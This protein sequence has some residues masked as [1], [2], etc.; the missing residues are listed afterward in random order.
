[1]AAGH[2]AALLQRAA[3]GPAAAARLS[4]QDMAALLNQSGTYLQLR[5]QLKA[6]VLALA[7]E[8]WAARSC[9]PAW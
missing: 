4:A 9:L 6:A 7:K 3:G 8:R 1:V 2:L 5:A